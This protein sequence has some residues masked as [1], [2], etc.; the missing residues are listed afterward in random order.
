V[1][2][3]KNISALTDWSDAGSVQFLQVMSPEV[4]AGDFSVIEFDGVDEVVFAVAGD[5]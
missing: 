4:D 5:C 1:P 3:V 2:T